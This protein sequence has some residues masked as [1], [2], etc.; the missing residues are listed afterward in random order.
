MKLRR[1]LSFDSPNLTELA[2]LTKR[3]ICIVFIHRKGVL[4]F[5][6]DIFKVPKVSCEKIMLLYFHDRELARG[7][8]SNRPIYVHVNGHYN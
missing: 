2:G 6:S 5:S 8:N 1:S 3:Y 4:S 7:E